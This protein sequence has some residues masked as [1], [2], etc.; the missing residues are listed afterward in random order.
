MELINTFD[1]SIIFLF[2]LSC[3][4]IGMILMVLI[5]KTV[6]AVLHGKK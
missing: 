3:I 2:G 4:I 5:Q 1:D 6:K